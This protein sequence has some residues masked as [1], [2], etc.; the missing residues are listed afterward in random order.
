VIHGSHLV[1]H[2]PVRYPDWTWG[3]GT[4]D[5][6]GYAGSGRAEFVAPN[7]ERYGVLGRIS[8]TIRSAPPAAPAR[9]SGSRATLDARRLQSPSPV[10]RRSG[11]TMTVQVIPVFI[12][13]RH[14]DARRMPHRPPQTFR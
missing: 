14:I 5:Y 9:P 2:E 13:Y 10:Q 3:E 12:A 11:A 7:L 8:G 6:A 4:G 1:T